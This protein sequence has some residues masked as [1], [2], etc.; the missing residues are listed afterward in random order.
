M[1]DRQFDVIILGGGMVGAALACALADSTLNIAVLDHQKPNI[2]WPIDGY[3]M[4]VSA[5]TYASQQI[6]QHIGVWQKMQEKRVTPFTR[7]HVWDSTGSGEIL[8]DAEDIGTPQLGHIVENRVTLGA[9]FDVLNAQSNIT[10]LQP[11]IAESLSQI[12]D[13]ICL[14][15]ADGSK[16]SAR[17]IVGAD[18]A[19]SWL[20]NQ[21]GISVTSRDYEQKG[22]VTTV[23]TQNSHDNTA[24]Q[25]FLPTGP[26]AFLPLDNDYCSIVWS[27]SHAEADRLLKLSNEAFMSELQEAI[28]ET[29]MGIIESAAARAAFPLKKQHADKYCQPNLVLVG[30]AAHTIHPLAG[31]GVNLGLLDIATLAEEMLS[32]IE[33]GRDF[34]GFQVL[35]R[36]ERRRKGDNAI[37]MS[38]MDAFHLLFANNNPALSTVRNLGLNITNQLTPIKSR[39]ISHA[40]GIN[41]KIPLVH[42]TAFRSRFA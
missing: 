21:A 1:K 13:G 32:A 17:L 37:M 31:Q 10:Y 23:K 40:M 12:D 34:N 27:T 3:D 41:R 2:T 28:G 29:D 4:R 18:G 19:R 35:R 22:V 36:Y 33:K 9:L 7:M 25:R 42:H 20:R 11:A 24:R 16:L 38:A 8:F 15:L 39:L 5:I 6:L 14:M 30:D 26:V